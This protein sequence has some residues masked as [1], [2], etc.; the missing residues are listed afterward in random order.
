VTRL[1]YCS[2][3]E[4]HIVHDLADGTQRRRRVRGA[5][6]HRAQVQVAAETE[7]ERLRGELAEQ[8]A[9][10]QRP[11]EPQRPT[12]RPP[13][14][15]G[16]FSHSDVTSLHHSAMAPAGFGERARQGAEHPDLK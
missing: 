5:D 9:Q 8:I 4:A 14:D 15:N 2:P 10:A 3:L 13:A 16:L 11:P 7:L 12:T 6:L 1:E